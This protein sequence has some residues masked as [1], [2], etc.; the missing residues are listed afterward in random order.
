MPNSQLLYKS[1]A[2]RIG[3]NSGVLHVELYA[4]PDEIS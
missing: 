4:E 2:Q 1:G 3:I